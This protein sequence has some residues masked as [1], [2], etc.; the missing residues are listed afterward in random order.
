MS[1]DAINGVA[2]LLGDFNPADTGGDSSAPNV[3]AAPAPQPQPQT[4]PAP[5]P[6]SAPQPPAMPNAKDVIQA[7]DASMANHSKWA[8]VVMGALK[9]LAL[10]GVPGAVSGAINPKGA[11]EGYALQKASNSVRFN[12]QSAQ[13]ATSVANALRSNYELEH[14]PE[15]EREAADE[16]QLKVADFLEHAGI[17]PS[18]IAP[19][20]GDSAGSALDHLQRLNGGV[21]P[22]LATVLHVGGMLVGF[23]SHA[24]APDDQLSFINN[25]RDV[26]GLPKLTSDA[27]AALNPQQKSQA[28]T[29]AAEVWMPTGE[30]L[31]PAQI[32]STIASKQQILKNYSARA[33]DTPDARKNVAML[34]SEID[35]LRSMQAG[36]LKAHLDQFREEEKI[37]AQFSPQANAPAYAV[38]AAG[39]TVLTTTAQAT[40]SGMTA[41]RPVHQ[42]DI[43]KDQHDIKVLSDIQTKSNNVAQAASAMDAT[44]WTD[45]VGVAK[46]LADNPNTTLSSL[47]R[48]TAFG[49]MTP[50]AKNYTVAVLSLRE[51][52]MGLQKVLTGSARSNETQINAL[53]NTLPGLEPDATTVRA[54]LQAFDQNLGLLAKGLPKGTGVELQ[55]FNQPAQST[56][57]RVV[58]AGAIPGRDA[59]GN[60]IGYKT[61]DGKVV[62]F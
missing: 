12:F 52:A 14:L 10:G 30:A 33:Y 37:R 5:Q 36:Q 2:E 6:P 47:M 26:S 29:G 25:S 39:D 21:V 61:A 20:T 34:E 19:D 62:K 7:A 40:A 48:S 9:G 41:I 15:L 24:S 17:M 58:P 56:P 49:A 35:M 8:N 59:A 23:T 22:Q 3:N 11:T 51:S 38:N 28:L 16:H 4:S 1:S 44:A 60:I 54:K 27:W 43:S 32:V 57:Q 55:G 46:Y 31:S 45:T 42:A 50:A 53:L 18:V 13:A